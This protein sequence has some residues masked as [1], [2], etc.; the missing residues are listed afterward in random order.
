M[1]SSG[2]PADVVQILTPCGTA[3]QGQVLA[4]ARNISFT[5]LRQQGAAMHTSQHQPWRL[6]QQGGQSCPLPTDV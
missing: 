1:K 2:T 5:G 4:T 6:S 3:F